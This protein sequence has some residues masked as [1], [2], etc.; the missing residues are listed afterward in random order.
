M[1]DKGDEEKASTKMDAEMRMEMGMGMKYS[2]V[3]VSPAKV[4]NALRSTRKNAC[5]GVDR[6]LEIACNPHNDTNHG[7]GWRI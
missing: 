1:V 3:C 7:E 5:V 2:R 6:V 4:W